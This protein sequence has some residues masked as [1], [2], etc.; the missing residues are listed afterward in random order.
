V[1]R[2]KTL[3]IAV[4]IGAVIGF[5]S[6]MPLW[7]DGGEAWELLLLISL[8]GFIVAFPVGAMGIVGNMH[9]PNAVVTGVVDALFYAWLFYWLITWRNR[10]E[11]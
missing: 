4:S 10:G 3:L 8:P 11:L 1:K 2:R 6:T 5:V 7:I 9:D